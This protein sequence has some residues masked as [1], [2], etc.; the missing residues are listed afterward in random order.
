MSRYFDTNSIETRCFVFCSRDM[1]V[2]AACAAYSLETTTMEQHVYVVFPNTC[3]KR[4]WSNAF[5]A[6]VKDV[7]VAIK[8]H[9]ALFAIPDCLLQSCHLLNLD[10]VF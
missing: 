9:T 2:Y 4:K 8:F 1:N 6:G 5:T 10:Y 7:L 3:E